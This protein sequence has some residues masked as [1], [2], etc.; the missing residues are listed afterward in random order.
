MSDKKPLGTFKRLLPYISVYKAAIGLAVIALIINSLSETYMI[1]LLKPLLDEGF[2]SDD[3]DFLSQMPYLILIIMFVRGASGF[4]STYCMRWVSSN[5][6][7]KIRREIFN[8]F[9][10]MPV[11]F[12]NK[13]ATGELLSRITYDSEQ[14]ASAS[15]SAL[16]KIVRESASIIG[17]LV[18]MFWS[19]W[20]LSMVLVVV[21]P[22]VAF[23]ISVVSKRFRKVSKNMQTSMGAL[24]SASEQMLQGHKTV[25]IFGGQKIESKRFE[26]VS[27][28]MRQQ[29]MKL[30]VAQGLSSPII[31]FI[32]SLALVSVLVLAN[33]DGIKENLTAGTFTVVFSA[34][35][36]LLRPLKGLTSVTADFQRGL[37]ACDT[38]F[39]LLDLEPEKDNGTLKTDIRGEIKVEGVNFKYPN[40]EK[41]IF[42]NLSV[43]IK[44]GEQVAFV[45][46]SGS[47][48]S[49][50]ANLLPRFYD[51]DHGGIKLDGIDIREYSLKHLRSNIAI[52]SQDVHLFNDTVLNNIAYASEGKYSIEEIK[53]AAD[54]ANATEFINKLDNGFDAVIG[55]NG[56]LL[57]GGQRQRL[58]I[59]R[60]LLQDAPIL[61]LDEATSALDNESEKFIQ[62]ALK[63]LKKGK[64]VITIAHRLSTIEDSDTIY[65]FNDGEIVESG[66][67]NQLLEKN[68][69]YKMLYDL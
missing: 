11:S 7:M 33:M 60:A 48:K 30:V 26:E 4:I 2:G 40:A 50:F 23:A 17:L 3:S 35:F 39:A 58:S 42:T 68:G 55:E 53:R 6:V 19:S 29:S 43:D 61:I 62:K 22:V 14:I 25:L 49:T 63:E 20:E 32:A 65:V 54:L 44:E 37:A 46:H 56:S 64:T 34:M 45:G 18:L 51:V 41:N 16:V 1:S 52:V 13:E 15:S 8:H 66:S 21:I 67:H 28:G 69:S 31:Q 36:G 38:L 12:F 59:A 10:K 9:M 5:I 57:S 27:N 47:G 24:T